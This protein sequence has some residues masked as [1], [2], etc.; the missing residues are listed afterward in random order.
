MYYSYMCLRQTSFVFFQ[1]VSQLLLFSLSI[2]F[3]PLR[4]AITSCRA[5]TNGTC[6]ASHWPRGYAS[7]EFRGSRGPDINRAAP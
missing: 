1:W 6:R 3:D 4:H 7:R 5:S 2:F